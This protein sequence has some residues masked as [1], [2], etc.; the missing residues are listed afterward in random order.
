MARGKKWK[1]KLDEKYGNVPRQALEEFLKTC[2]ICIEGTQRI[3]K[4]EGIKPIITKGFNRRGQVDLIDFQSH[5]DEGMHWLLVYQDH[6]LKFCYLIP[7]PSKHA[8]GIAEK[9]LFIFTIQGAP[10]IL[11]SD[12]GREF[13]NQVIRELASLWPTLKI[14]HGRPRHSESQGGVEKLNQQVEKL[15]W[16]F[17]K[18]NKKG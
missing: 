2:P 7:L 11:Q 18:E 16:V 14:V 12:N 8:K 17:M 13:E 10:A 1:K 4:R 3:S 15:L 9:L 5:P 6:G